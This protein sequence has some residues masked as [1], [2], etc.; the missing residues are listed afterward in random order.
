MIQGYQVA[1]TPEIE[2]Y[3]RQVAAIES[4]AQDVVGGLIVAEMNW[5]PAQFGWSIGECIEHLNL[6]GRCF[7]RAIEA[8][9]DEA[10]AQGWR[11]TGP[12]HY[13]KFEAWWV[14]HT[15]PNAM[16]RFKTPKAFAPAPGIYDRTVVEEFLMIQRELLELRDR[17]D[18]IDL[19]KAK[20][21]LPSPRFLKLSLGQTFALVLAHERRHLWQA[22][23]VREKLEL[24]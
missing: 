6:M 17:A 11:H 12:F 18:S 5:R 15:E 4:D 7:L 2:D 9:V 8:A 14:N 13:G 23:E 1:T 21:R 16:I 22:W 20:V 3:Q 19:T 24:P 10:L